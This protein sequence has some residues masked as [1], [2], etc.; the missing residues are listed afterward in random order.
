MLTK[1]QL[2]KQVREL[3]KI[4][5]AL[6]NESRLRWIANLADDECLHEAINHAMKAKIWL[7]GYAK[8]YKL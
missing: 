5:D 2:T 6:I 7:E 8:I 4:I 3:D 1:R